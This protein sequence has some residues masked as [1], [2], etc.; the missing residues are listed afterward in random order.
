[1]GWNRGEDSLK[2]PLLFFVAK[3]ELYGHTI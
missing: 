3:D 2:S 1:L